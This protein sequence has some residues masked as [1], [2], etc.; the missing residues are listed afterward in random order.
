M[1]C[2]RARNTHNACGWVK[3]LFQL[4]SK[5]QDEQNKIFLPGQKSEIAETDASESAMTDTPAPRRIERSK[6]LK[7]FFSKSELETGTAETAATAE[8]DGSAATS[9]SAPHRVAAPTTFAEMNIRA[10]DRMPIETAEYSSSGGGKG[11]RL[12]GKVVG[13][14]EGSSLLVSIQQNA[15]HAGLVRENE[16]VLLR[17]FTGQN[18]FAFHSTIVK[19]THA[20]YTYMHLSFPAHV[21]AVRIRTSV[22]QS[23]R[24][25]ITVA[26]AD[27]T[28]GTQGYM[29]NIGVNGACI[30]T[31][32]PLK[33]VSPL[34]IITQFELYDVQ[35]PL[36]VR[37]RIRSSKELPS[38]QAPTHY[39]YGVEFQDLQPSD[40]VAL[41]SLLWYE[42][43]THPERIV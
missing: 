27:E 12:V 24:F 25:P 20:P 41:G 18:A 39:E 3:S 35:V 14:L 11:K 21:Q 15:V 40:R 13:W 8:T 30:S 31:S 32:Q 26:V 43:H 33:D 23:V 5:D 22:R 16:Q 28:T 42:M 38:E 10:G 36:K 2:K 29:L 37:A 34:R 1:S 4:S 6:K 7:F 17:A 19:I 9:T